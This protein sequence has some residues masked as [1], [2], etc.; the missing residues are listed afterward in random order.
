MKHGNNAS[1]GRFGSFDLLQL[2]NYPIPYT[3]EDIHYALQDKHLAFLY[4]K[5][6][7][8]VFKYANI[9]RK[10]FGKP[11]VFNLL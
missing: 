4:A 10:K 1:S 6:L 5:A 9:A 3:K 7:Y 2:M 8:P 11:T